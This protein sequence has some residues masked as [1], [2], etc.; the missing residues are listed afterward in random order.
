MKR[1]IQEGNPQIPGLMREF[2]QAIQERRKQR[3][4]PD[5]FPGR[6]PR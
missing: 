5:R 2:H 1:F 3:G 6:G 4:L